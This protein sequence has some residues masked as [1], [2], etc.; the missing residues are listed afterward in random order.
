MNDIAGLPYAEAQFDKTGKPENAFAVPAGI[1]DLF[2]VSHG[3]NNDADAARALYRELF[4]NFVGVGKPGDFPGRTFA[5]AGVIWPSKKFDELVAASGVSGNAQG[6]AALQAHDQRS[7]QAIIEKLERMK[8]FFTEPGQRQILDEVKALLPDLE[9]KGSARQ[10]FVEKVRS[11]L[12]PA[13]AEKE[14]SSRAFFRDDG[15]ELMANLKVDEDDLDPEI[16]NTAGSASLPLGVG[17]IDAGTGGAAKFSDLLSGFKAA[18][19]NVL[20]YTTYYEMK[21]RAGEVGKNGVAKLLDGL[22][23]HVQRIHLVGHSFGGRVVAAAAANS[24]TNRIKSMTLLQAAFSHNGF[25][26]TEKGF[27]RA[28]VDKKRVDGPILITHTKND[29]AVGVAY[30]LASRLKGDKAA[31]LGDANDPFGGIG[32]NGTQKMDQDEAIAGQLLAVNSVYTFQPRKFF[33]LE[34]SSFITGHSDVRGKEVAYA[35]RRLIV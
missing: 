14:D 15:D 18:A 6:A 31:A 32:R 11:L 10:A 12:D 7:D 22:P 1:T 2:V 30:P 29:K 33:N 34:A 20:N 35:L 5:V 9:E 8:D 3:W 17:G 25:S 21:A 26:R 28:V 4:T 16:A 19:L 27:F 13:H 23:A 24:T